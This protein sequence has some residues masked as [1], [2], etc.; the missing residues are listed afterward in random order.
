MGPPYLGIHCKGGKKRQKEKGSSLCANTKI[1][2]G[3]MQGKTECR[4][5]IVYYLSARERE[6][7]GNKNIN[8]CTPICI[9]KYSKRNVREK[10]LLVV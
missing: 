7:M 2:P 5:S 3:Y 9:N 10:C 8:I 6:W 1:F 4:I